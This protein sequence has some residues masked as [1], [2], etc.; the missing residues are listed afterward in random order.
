[1]P[2]IAARRFEPPP[3]RRL[4]RPRPY[5]LVAVLSSLLMPLAAVLPLL[6]APACAAAV[7]L[8]AALGLALAASLRHAAAQRCRI[9]QLAALA[10]AARLGFW[11]QAVGCTH[12]EWSPE[13]QRLL[14]VV[15]PCPDIEEQAD[16]LHPDDRDAVQALARRVAV[17]LR[18]EGID[19]RAVHPILGLRHLRWEM[20]PETDRHGRL[21]ALW[22][23][24]QDIT[25]RRAAEERQRQ[26]SRMDA[27]GQMAAGLAHDFNNLLCTVVLNLDMLARAEGRGGTQSV[28]NLAARARAAAERGAELTGQLLAFAGKRPMQVR[29]LDLSQAVQASLAALP[30]SP[31]VAFSLA[32]PGADETMT[33]EAD[34]AQVRAAV[35]AL[36]AH[37]Q[38]ATAAGPAARGDAGPAERLVRVTLAAAEL[39]GTNA[40]ALGVAAGRYAELA[41]HDDSEAPAPDLLPRLVEPFFRP[42]ADGRDPSG[43]GVHLAL[44]H[45]VA[46]GHAGCLTL[47]GRAGEGTTARLLLPLLAQPADAAD[48]A[49]PAVAAGWPLATLEGL[50]VLLVEDDPA[51]CETTAALLLEQGAAV[52]TAGDGAAALALLRGKQGF[53]LLLS[54]V[55]LPG[56]LSGLDVVEAAA[57]LRPGLAALLASGYAAP[58][59]ELGRPVPPGARLLHKP[60]RCAELLDAIG[61]ALAPASARPREVA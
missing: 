41:V 7:A 16:A 26:D 8:A 51:V 21:A 17:S 53:D 35:Q 32:R 6:H 52:T 1:M 61:T 25:D 30:P 15:Q 48:A 23:Y 40:A 24:A 5:L 31:G 55:V 38:Q 59:Q 43:T 54:D 27:L 37:A 12:G 49:G 56:A 10:A 47:E 9:D 28:A 39:D 50:R 19:V 44:A 22:G 34:P 18:G 11:R 14:G 13:L 36:L 2:A 3:H 45:G 20:R 57:A 29:H 42:A 4:S 60:Y 46:R 33:V 58:A